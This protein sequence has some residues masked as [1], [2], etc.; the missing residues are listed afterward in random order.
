[1]NQTIQERVVSML[2]HFG[3]SDSF[4]A[5]ALLTTVHIINMSPGRPLGLK[6]P[7]EIWTNSKP[8]Y[9]K[10]RIFGCEAYVLIPK[11][12]DRRKLKP[13]SRKCIFL[14]YAPDGNIRYRL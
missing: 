3:L 10:F 5:E 12:D 9:D 14:R 6:I 13:R 8:S 7:Q 11:E 2:Q 1:M 4:W